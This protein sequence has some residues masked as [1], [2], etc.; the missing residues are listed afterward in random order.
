MECNY[1]LKIKKF[2][3]KRNSEFDTKINALDIDFYLT[4][5]SLGN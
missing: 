1:N 4:N 5:L 2:K 3:A